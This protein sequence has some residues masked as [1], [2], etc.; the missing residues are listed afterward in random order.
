MH[1]SI[2]RALVSAGL[3]AAAAI[4]LLALG[5]VASADT[6]TPSPTSSASATASPSATATTTPAPALQIQAGGGETGIAVELFTPGS[7]TVQTGTVVTWKNP[8]GE[9]HTVTFGNPTSDPTVPENVPATGP[10]SY[11]GTGYFSSGLFA[12]GFSQGPPGSP[13][14]PD[15]FSVMFTKAGAYNYFC[16]IHTN[17]HG[18]VNVVDSGATDSQATVN[19][20][21][22]TQFAAGLASLKALQAQ[23][24]TTAKVSQNANGTKTYTITNGADNPNGD[25]VQFIP[26]AVNIAAGDT[27][28]WVA[29]TITPHTVTFNPDQFQGDPLHTPGT[30]AK[31][32]DGTGLA[33]SGI[34]APAD[35]PLS[36]AFTS[37]GTSFSLTFTKAGSYHYICLLHADEG[38]AGAV[39]VSAASVPPSPS[40]TTGTPPNPPNTGSGTS[41]GSGTTLWM[42]LGLAAAL[43]ALTGAGVFAVKRQR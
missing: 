16:A 1:M 25:L 5:G 42:G 36:Q 15:T 26:A 9:P 13:T 8:F 40:P 19:S 2:R 3:A 17:M 4:P 23:Q 11:D 39:N 28:T 21:I 35:D 6:P 41:S 27:V 30:T 43:L 12:P 10:V 38:M 22:Q 7:V 33:N 34:I 24:P 32:F 18:T 31:T 14:T 29:N 20:E 37:S